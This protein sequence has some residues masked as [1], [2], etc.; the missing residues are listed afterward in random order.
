MAW[1]LRRCLPIKWVGP[2]LSADA[3]Y[4]ILSTRVLR[5]GFST[6]PLA[7]LVEGGPLLR[8]PRQSA[9]AGIAVRSSAGA[10]V[11]VRATYVGEREDRRFHGAPN[12]DT[13]AVTLSPYTKLDVSGALPLALIGAPLRSF[14]ATVRV[15]NAL[16]ARYESVAGYATPGRVVLGGLRAT[17]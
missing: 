11:D 3:S 12:F 1:K 9:T 13:E 10:T 5:R 14:T 7:T 16:A 15:D 6:S 17:F 4:T 2:T 8:R